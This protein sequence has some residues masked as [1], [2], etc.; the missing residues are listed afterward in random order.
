VRTKPDDVYRVSLRTMA[1][2]DASLICA[3]FG[4]GGHANA[5]GCTLNGELYSVISDILG[6]VEDELRR[7]GLL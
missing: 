5:A 7:N 6:S 2:V 4:G 3:R 1:P